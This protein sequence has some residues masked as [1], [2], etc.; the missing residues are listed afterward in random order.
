MKNRQKK[1]NAN[2]T[3]EKKNANLVEDEEE[4]EKISN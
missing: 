1:K 4:I 3:E 2:L